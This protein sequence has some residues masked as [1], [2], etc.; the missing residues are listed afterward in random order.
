MRISREGKKY[1]SEHLRVAVS[2]N[3]LSCRRLGIAVSRK[4]GPAVARNRLKRLIR[5]TFR[6][7]KEALPPSLDLVVAAKEGAAGMSFWQVSEELK[8]I[9]RELSCS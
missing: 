7:N 9:W 5:E 1:Q 3:S 4:V 8:G 6:L 2:P